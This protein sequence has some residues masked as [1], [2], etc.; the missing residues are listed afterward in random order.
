MLSAEQVHRVEILVAKG[1]TIGQIEAATGHTDDTINKI[2]AHHHPIQEGHVP[3]AHSETRDRREKG[4][5]PGCGAVVWLPCRRCNTPPPL[6][7]KQI[8]VPFRISYAEQAAINRAADVVPRGA[9]DRLSQIATIAGVSVEVAGLI[10]R[11]SVPGPVRVAC[12][13][14]RQ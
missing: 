11:G 3:N 4:K 5:C 1:L 9:P 10:L 2:A 12:L 8:L 14:F 7:V 6:P 13:P